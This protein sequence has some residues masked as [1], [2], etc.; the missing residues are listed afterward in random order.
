MNWEESAAAVDDGAPRGT[1]SKTDR[2][3]GWG[4]ARWRRHRRY[5]L[6][7]LFLVSVFSILDRYILSILLEPIKAELGVSDTAMGFLNGLAF[8]FFNAVAAIPLARMSDRHSRKWIIALGL[9]AWSVLTALQGVAKTFTGLAAARIGVGI[10]EASTSPA[11]HSLISDY[12]PPNRRATAIS[13]FTTGGHI[14]LMLGLMLG[15]VLYG[16]L[17]W[18][19]TLIVVGL[20]GLALALLFVLT[21]KE[22][23]RGSEGR[24]WDSTSA[25]TETTASP[26]P[27]M[28]ALGSLWRLRSYRH[29]IFVLPLFVF[30]NYAINIW[31][32]VFMLRVHQWEIAQV[33]LWLGLTV[34]LC[35]MSGNIIGSM[36]CDRLG[37]RDLRWYLWAPALAAAI[38]LPLYV[39][40]LFVPDGIWALCLLGVSI[41]LVSF[42]VSPIYAMAQGLA[43]TRTRATASA[44]IHLMAAVLGAGLGPF[45]I[46]WLND[47]LQ[48]FWGTQSIRYSLLLV[49]P[50]VCLGIYLA[51]RGSQSLHQELRL[52]GDENR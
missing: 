23:P 12:F 2:S 21:V 35:G 37:E 38:M 18:R 14:G 6:A 4:E 29:I 43:D 1:A 40:F 49:L 34:G 28:Q 27:L 39:S 46:G 42:H 26:P 24:P 3:G 5:V 17:G 45:V 15:G 51:W 8:A 10:G 7:L 9:G 19:M 41:F 22:P 44:Q 20:P 48:P 36:L 47:L 30:T 50:S 32:A 52:Q 31:G 13:L 16:Y 11:A 25:A 33:G